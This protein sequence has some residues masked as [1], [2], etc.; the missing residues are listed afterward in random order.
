MPVIYE[1]MLLFANT[2]SHIL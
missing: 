2:T 1:V